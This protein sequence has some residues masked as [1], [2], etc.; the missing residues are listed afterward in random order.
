M[1]DGGVNE[2]A[3]SERTSQGTNS[4]EYAQYVRRRIE[5]MEKILLKC[6]ALGR[7]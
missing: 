2:G 1:G 7:A 4:E 6:D 5:S 3:G